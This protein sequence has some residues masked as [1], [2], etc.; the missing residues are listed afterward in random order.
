LVLQT[1]G[2]RRGVGVHHEDEGEQPG[3]AHGRPRRVAL[4]LYAGNRRQACL[5]LNWNFAP[6]RVSHSSFK[7]LFFCSGGL[8]PAPSLVEKASLCVSRPVSESW[9]RVC[10]YEEA[11]AKS[12][13]PTGANRISNQ[14]G[15]IS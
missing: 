13:C 11:E 1:E 8:G 2:S 10:P 15:K 7:A 6:Q 14:R 4:R 9:R 5:V 3:L 12:P